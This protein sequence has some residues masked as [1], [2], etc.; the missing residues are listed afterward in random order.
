MFNASCEII[1]KQSNTIKETL[2]QLWKD[3]FQNLDNNQLFKLQ[4]K[5]R[6]RN[7]DYTSV[8]YVQ[9]LNKEDLNTAIDVFNEFWDRQ[10]NY[11]NVWNRTNS[12][13]MQW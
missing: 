3:V 9:I 11:A 6:L 13:L 12:I 8:S 1:N 2:S 10:E 7:T 5:L 4:I